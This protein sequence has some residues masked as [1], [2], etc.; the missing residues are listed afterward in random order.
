MDQLKELLERFNLEFHESKEILVCKTCP[1]VLN[2]DLKKHLKRHGMIIS[3]KEAAL[4]QKCIHYASKYF[5]PVSELVEPVEGFTIHDGFKCKLCIYYARDKYT[6]R[7]HNRTYHEGMEDYEQCY[8]QKLFSVGRFSYVGV[9][10]DA[11]TFSPERRR[12]KS[13]GSTQKISTKTPKRA[14][15]ETKNISIRGGSGETFA[16]EVLNNHFP[17]MI[18]YMT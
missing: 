14:L 10:A 13:E 9:V 15:L 1:V 3:N 4:L 18:G 2:Y 6:L 7:Q 12:S 17:C 11:A 5:K 8:V 16:V